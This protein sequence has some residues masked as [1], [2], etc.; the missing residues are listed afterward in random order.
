MYDGFP[1][2]S[3]QYSNAPYRVAG[4]GWLSGTTAESLKAFVERVF[5]NFATKT[6]FI[7][8]E[9]KQAMSKD[10]NTHSH[11]PSNTFLDV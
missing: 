3:V 4:V 5:S 7:T 10:L 8:I 2:S 1:N 9:G 11:V 6:S